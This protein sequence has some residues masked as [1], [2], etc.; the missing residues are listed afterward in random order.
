MLS[1]SGGT[2]SE[3]AKLTDTL[4]ALVHNKLAFHSA[5]SKAAGVAT[6]ERI[7]AGRLCHKLD[8]RCFTLL[9]LPTILRQGKEQPRLVLG[10]A[11]VGNGCD[12]EP[13]IVVYRCDFELNFGSCLDT[14]RR[15]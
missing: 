6:L 14:K 1:T 15:R 8:R 10:F 3:A 7:R 11:A 13:M 2:E 12:L 4:E 5:M 9:Q